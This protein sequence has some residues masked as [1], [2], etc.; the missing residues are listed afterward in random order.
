MTY[1]ISYFPIPP[2]LFRSPNSISTTSLWPEYRHPNLTYI[3]FAVNGQ[4]TGNSLITPSLNG[5][6]Y[7]GPSLTGKSFI[8]PGLIVPILA[9]N[10]LIVTSLG[11]SSLIQTRLTGSGLTDNRISQNCKV[12]L[13]DVPKLAANLAAA[14]QG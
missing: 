9:A 12:W 5:K 3:E 2:P 8:E 6:S 7:F 14:A 11:G 4:A 1:I 10:G 13:E